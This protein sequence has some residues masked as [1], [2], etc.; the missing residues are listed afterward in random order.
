M[1]ATLRE[2]VT[3]LTFKVDKFSLKTAEAMMRNV[4]RAIVDVDKHSKRAEGSVKRFSNRMRGIKTAAIAGGA[5]IAG[6]GVALTGMM[7]KTAMAFEQLQTVLVT[8]EGSEK[9]A[10]E[11]MDWVS[12]FAQRTPF[13]LEEVTQAF[14][15]MRAYGLD[16]TNGSLATLGD[17]SAAMGK[18]V[19]QGVEMMADAVT[20]EFERLKEFGIKGNKQGGQATFQFTD[21]NGI[22]Q[23]RRVMAND[24]KAIEKAILDIFSQKYDGA[25]IRLSGTM[26]GIISN[27]QDT[28]ARF[29][30]QVMASGAFEAIKQ[31]LLGI[32]ETLNTMSQDGRLAAMAE[33]VGGALLTIYTLIKQTI[34]FIMDNQDL[35]KIIGILAGVA[36]LVP[37][38][39]EVAAAVTAVVTA[40]VAFGEAFVV[41]S[42]VLG[43]LGAII[44]GLNLPMIAIVGVL[45]AMTAGILAFATN[46]GGFRDK[47]VQ[48]VKDVGNW[49]KWL[50]GVIGST[51]GAAI[52]GFKSIANIKLPTLKLPGQTAT[53]EMNRARRAQGKGG[54]SKSFTNTANTTVNINGGNMSQGRAKQLGASFSAGSLSGFRSLEAY[55][56]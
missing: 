30:Q 13:E 20:G 26:G 55:G 17:A 43:P 44:A 38:F 40:A 29:Q 48:A 14:V 35:L 19:M 16:P 22:Q 1:M 54:G 51:V 11:A 39:I 6:V 49:F 32:L 7:L 37:I 23:T 42:A 2:L 21:K 8:T 31:D 56:I 46:A 52:R 9:A 34:K 27:L 53:S 28:F 45:A 12:S 25:M 50:G 15:R 47:T 33:K 36:Y 18:N 24:R 4:D 3:E 41:A 10:K 5:A